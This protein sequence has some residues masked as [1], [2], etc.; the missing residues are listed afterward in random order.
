MFINRGFIQKKK[1][2]NI[3]VSLHSEDEQQNTDLLQ[4]AALSKRVHRL[5]PSGVW[6]LF[7]RQEAASAWSASPYL[8]KGTVILVEYLR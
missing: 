3:L 6:L 5:M 2:N 1:K 7:G 4:L 8:C